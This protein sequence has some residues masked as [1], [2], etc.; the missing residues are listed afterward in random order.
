MTGF[1]WALGLHRVDLAVRGGP[2]EQANDVRSF[3]QGIV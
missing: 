2:V 1:P 3:L